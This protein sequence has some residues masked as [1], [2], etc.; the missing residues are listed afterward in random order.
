MLQLTYILSL[1]GG[2]DLCLSLNFAFDLFNK[3]VVIAS[4]RSYRD[5]NMC[6]YDNMPL[7]MVFSLAAC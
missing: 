5:K 3:G 1:L 2:R 4:L 6:C 7:G